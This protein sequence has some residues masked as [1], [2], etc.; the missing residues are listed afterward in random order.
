[1]LRIEAPSADSAY[2]PGLNPKPSSQELEK[3]PTTFAQQGLKGSAGVGL[4][5]SCNSRRSVSVKPGGPP[6]SQ[7]PSL[8]RAVGSLLGFPTGL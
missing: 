6:P 8:S 7:S 2:S 1:M 3:N 5:F 4:G